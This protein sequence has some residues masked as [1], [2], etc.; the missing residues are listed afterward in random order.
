MLAAA[1]PKLLA[2]VAGLV[3]VAVQPLPTAVFWYAMEI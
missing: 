1:G 3:T 2:P